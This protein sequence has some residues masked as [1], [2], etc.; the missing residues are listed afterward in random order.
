M[1]YLV[2]HSTQFKIYVSMA[3]DI[4]LMINETRCCHFM[5]SSFQL[6]A[7]G[8]LYSPSLKQYSTYH[9]LHN[10]SCGALVGM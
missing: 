5:G 3:L 10:V 9:V 4:W 8:I 2:M 1:F 6:A 7:R